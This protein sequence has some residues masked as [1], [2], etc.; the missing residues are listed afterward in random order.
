M[1]RIVTTLLMT[2][3]LSASVAPAA[4]AN[5]LEGTGCKLAEKAGIVFIREC[6]NP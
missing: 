2:A 6:G 1:R 3:A 5:P 4:V